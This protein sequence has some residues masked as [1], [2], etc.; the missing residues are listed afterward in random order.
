MRVGAWLSVGSA[1]LLAF[2]GCGDSP[3]NPA[4]DMAMASACVDP[5]GPGTMHPGSI[6]QNETWTAAASPHV[7]AQDT[8]ITAVVTLE[9]CTL[10]LVGPAKT[11]SVFGAGSIVAKGTASQPV[12]FAA[13]DTTKPWA[14]I[15]ASAG[16]TLRFEY[17][18]LLGGGDRLNYAAYL[19]AVLD[20]RADQSLPPAE[21]LHAD[22]LLI[23][24]SASNG[25]YLH[26]GGGFSATSTAVKI[27]GSMGYPIHTWS[28]LAG[29][30]PDGDY[31]GNASDEILLTASGMQEGIIRDVTFHDRG[32]PYH[33]GHPA[34]A[35]TLRVQSSTVGVPA[36]LTLEPG[37][38]LRF[39]KGGDLEVEHFDTT[40]P[41]TGA[42]IAVGTAARPITFT[43]AEP[44]PAAGD[45]SGL[46]FGSLPDP[47]DRMDQTVIEYAGGQYA[48]AMG[49]SCPYP[50]MPLNDAAVRILGEPATEFITNT[51]FKDSSSHAV[52]RAFKSDAPPDF[53][54]TNAFIN[55]ARCKQ[56]LPRT[57]TPTTCPTDPPCP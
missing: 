23:Q 22:H 38:T 48:L 37:V 7:L 20:I 4:P 2:A 40:G 45:W 56:T 39:K 8:S 53:I 1:S 31:T 5:T 28:N 14:A 51:L 16:G 18:G 13:L 32:V 55:V 25:I 21:I 19:G 57:V 27:T 10:V 47:S 44:V 24:D 54:A 29:T 46:W 6:T 52:D 34:S 33:V 12:G 9:P 11:I 15:R 41:A 36:T 49:N 43:S 17:T 35:A 3:S 26:E 50:G 42:L 30:I